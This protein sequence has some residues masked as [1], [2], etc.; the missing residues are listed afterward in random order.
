MQQLQDNI[1]NR[2][3]E[4]VPVLTAFKIFDPLAVLQKSETTFKEYG[5][6]EMAVL[7]DRFYQEMQEDVKDERKEELICEW[8]KFKYN[9]LDY[10][11]KYSTCNPQA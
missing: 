8:K 11:G 2:F 4:S 7:A 10:Q 9:L 3:D 5:L 1:N 6:K